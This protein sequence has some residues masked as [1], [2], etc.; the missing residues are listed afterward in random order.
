M[1]TGDYLDLYNGTYEAVL[2]S[3]NPALVD[4]GANLKCNISDIFIP[5]T[6]EIPTRRTFIYHVRHLNASAELI[7]GLWCIGLKRSRVR[8]DATTQRGVRSAILPLVH[9]YRADIVFSMRRINAHFATDS[10][11]T[12]NH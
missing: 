3:I 11:F 12:L 10:F 2:H 7:V 6:D 1:E 4:M 9:R 8:L 5:A